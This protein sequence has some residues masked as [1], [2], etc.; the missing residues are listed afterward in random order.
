M[1]RVATRLP[2][3]GQHRVDVEVALRGGR[4]PD[5][6][7]LV[8]ETDVS[9]LPV[10]LRVDGDGRDAELGAGRGVRGLP[11]HPRLATRTFRTRR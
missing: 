8:G 1:E 10:G 9:G 5:R 7:R 2:T 6:D 4:R 11:P 3:R